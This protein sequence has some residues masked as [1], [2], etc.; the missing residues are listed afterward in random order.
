M[1]QGMAVTGRPPDRPLQVWILGH[2]V[3]EALQERAGDARRTADHLGTGVAALVVGTDAQA[4]EQLIA[5]GVDVVYWL[6]SPLGLCL[7]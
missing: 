7:R 3:D 5:Y 1:E 6:G 4:A 2:G